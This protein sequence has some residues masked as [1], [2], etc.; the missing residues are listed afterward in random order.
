M[1]VLLLAT[2]E[3]ESRELNYPVTEENNLVNA[4]LIGFLDPAKPFAN[5]AIQRFYDLGV[6]VKVLTGDNELVTK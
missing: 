6:S 1:R 2:R 5:D 4:G 3:F